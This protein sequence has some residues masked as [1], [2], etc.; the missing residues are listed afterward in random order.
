MTA[1]CK[2]WHCR[3]LF[4]LPSASAA[5]IAEARIGRERLSQGPAAA[6]VSSPRLLEQQQQAAQRQAQ[7]E[8]T[9]SDADV[10]ADIS[11]LLHELAARPAMDG[12]WVKRRTAMQRP[13]RTARTSTDARTNAC[14]GQPSPRGVGTSVSRTS[15]RPANS[16]NNMLGIWA[17]FDVEKQACAALRLRERCEF[18][19]DDSRS[20]FSLSA[21]GGLA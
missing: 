10:E 4:A 17:F 14:S 12:R 5:P 20:E 8:T 15:A 19:G 7:R 11:I 3:L 13:T 6:H 16:R 2:T 1:V 9:P 21:T 18:F